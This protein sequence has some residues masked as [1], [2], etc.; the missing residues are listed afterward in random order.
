MASSQP[1]IRVVLVGTQRVI[2]DSLG[3]FI[4]QQPDLE[5]PSLPT[6]AGAAAEADVALFDLDDPGGIDATFERLSATAAASRTIALTVS[7]TPALY[8]RAYQAGA[9]G[10]ILEV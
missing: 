6:E 8:F 9:A 3:G 2:L 7:P 10:L 1:I 4:E 5:V